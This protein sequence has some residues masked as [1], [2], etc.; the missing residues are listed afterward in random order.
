MTPLGG[1]DTLRTSLEK[2]RK[3][4]KTD[5]PS[6]QRSAV[7]TDTLWMQF[8]KTGSVEDYLR[9]LQVKNE[10]PVKL[11]NAWFLSPS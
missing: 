5:F 2:L 3:M 7:E 1:G 9:F 4:Q 11:E 6:E 8:E 10:K